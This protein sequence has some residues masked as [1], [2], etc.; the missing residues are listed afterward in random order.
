[1]ILRWKY[2]SV[3]R[4]LIIAILINHLNVEFHDSRHIEIQPQDEGPAIF[5]KVCAI[6]A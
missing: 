3:N 5:S 2:N 1:M 4:K 6:D